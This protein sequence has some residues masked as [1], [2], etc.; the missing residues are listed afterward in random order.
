[1]TTHFPETF[2]W[3]IAASSPQGEGAAPASDWR[4]WELA[5]KVPP[6]GAGNG[7]ATT[8]AEDFRRCAEYGL[9]HYRL[10]IEWARI[11]PEAGRRDP[12]AV[13]HYRAVLEAARETGIEPWVCLHHFT[14]P[15]WLTEDGS[16]F[17]DERARTY[18]WRR[19]VEFVAETYGSL[20]FGWQPVNEP[21]NY[22]INGFLDGVFP[23]GAR[24]QNLA[25]VA[26]EGAY[27]ASA[28]AAGVLRQTAKPVATV[29][30]LAPVFP[31]DD[32]EDSAAV[33]DFVEEAAWGCW[34]RALREGVLTVPGRPPVAVPAFVEAFD[35]IGF[36]YYSAVGLASGP[37]L[38]PYPPGAR[39]G[40][41]S[42]APWSDG[43]GL[44]LDRLTWELPGRAFLVAEHGV[45]TD[46]DAWRCEILHDSLRIVADRV[47]RGMD[48][49][50]FFHWT[51]V[52]NYEWQHGF[53]VP[54]G[55]F[56]RAR[57]PR[58]SAELLGHVATSGRL[59][60]SGND[61]ETRFG[62]K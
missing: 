48:L 44:V 61:Y 16:G 41:L 43:L 13:E 17:C 26:L 15:V 58:A 25:G 9:R 37:R 32:S 53:E 14:L 20:V 38:V 4:A 39:V 8:Y 34:L 7:F 24:D 56:D 51:G 31:A 27:L 30:A 1:M 6:S 12:E 42:Y 28:E 21:L 29:Q 3:G 59:P 46:D 2:W 50:G 49:R 33:V 60:T 11:E 22:A 10:G 52:D 47:N 62:V 5:E 54:F 36:S 35:L 19:H 40:P 23:P 45:G 57:R 18:Y 55:I